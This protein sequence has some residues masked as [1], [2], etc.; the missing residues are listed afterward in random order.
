MTESYQLRRDTCL[1]AIDAALAA[2]VSPLQRRFV[3]QF[4]AKIQTIEMDK[5]VP[6]VAGALALSAFNFAKQRMAGKP[7][8]RVFSPNLATDGWESHRLV[9]ELLNDDMPFLVDSLSAEMVRQGFTVYETLHPIIMV[10]R[11]ESGELLE[12]MPAASRGAAKES[13]IHFELS[14]LPEGVSVEQLEA[15]L[16]SVLE[17]VRISVLDW[18]ALMDKTRAL[19]QSLPHAAKHF[20]QEDILEAQDFLEWMIDRNFVFLGYAAIAYPKKASGTPEVIRDTLLGISRMDEIPTDVKTSSR[21]IDVRKSDRKSVVH[22][23]AL[24]DVVIIKS[25][26]TRGEIIGEHRLYGL[27]TSSVYYQSSESIPFV[28]QKVLHVLS[29]SGFDPVSHD[30]KSLKAILEFLPRDEMFQYT[31]DALLELGLGILALEARPGVRVFTRKDIS[32]RLVNCMVFVPRE[33][34]STELR[35]EICRLLE[36]AYE[37]AL[38]N[39]YTQITDSPL[40]RLHLILRTPQGSEVRPDIATVEAEIAGFTTHWSDKLRVL[41]IARFG[42]TKGERLTRLFGSGFP[43]SYIN[44]FDI[45]SILYDADRMDQALESKSIALELFRNKDEDAHTLHLKIYNPDEEIALSDILPTLEHMGLRAIEEHPFRIAVAGGGRIWIRD[46]R[47][48]HKLESLNLELVKPLFEETLAKV[49]RKELEDDRFNALVLSAQ[50]T[51]R[52]VEILRAYSKY[53][54]QI[55]FTYGPVAIANTLAASAQA[56]RLLV[57]LFE[58]RFDPSFEDRAGATAI[59]NGEMEKAF[60]QATTLAEDRILRA[61]Q[62]LLHA[63]LRTNYYCRTP[64][65]GLKPVLSF[66]FNSKAVPELPLP[67]PH[68]EIF[69]Y[70]ARVEGIHLRG[71]KVA[72]GGL[73]WS[74]RPEDFRTEILGLMKAQMVKNSVI[75]P[76]GSKGGFVVKQP[77]ADPSREAQMKEGIACYTLYL[78]GLLDITD[79]IVEARIVPPPQVVRHDGDDPY[80]V[81]AADKGTATFSDIANS[82]SAAYQ[83]WL[84]DAFASGGSAGYDHKKMA[85]TARGAWVSV[86]RHFREMGVDIAQQDFTAV[87]IGDMSGDVFGNGMLLSK[88]IRLV[89]AFNH[90]H[91][92]IDPSPDAKTSFEERK[93]LFNLPRSGWKDYD[94]K[95]ISKGGGV[96]ERS[97]KRIDLSPEAMRVLGLTEASLTPDALITAILKAPV[98]L[99]WN[100]GIGTYVKS[101]EETHEQVGDR[102]N[103]AVRISGAEVRARVVGEGGN[104]GFTQRGR[105][106]YARAGGRINT[107][108]IDN[109]AGVDCSDH[110]VN[111]KITFASALASGQMKLEERNALLVSMTDEV[112]R[113]VLRDNE[114]QTLAISIAQSQG[115]SLLLV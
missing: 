19:G 7:K 26:N 16:Q 9:V 58:A 78:Q 79:N 31:E 6:E 80:L 43:A 102:T 106:E 92:F 48:I 57:R 8:I 66:K 101:A 114:L 73:R 97:Q 112:A 52:Q 60:A 18:Q 17:H 29:R 61:L 49:W 10:K 69:V 37:G 99:L 81:V 84:G 21:L 76:V 104:L 59:L 107:D 45:S 56:A 39:F 46:V 50:L 14:A 70:A 68:A 94:V 96:Y 13:L 98:D 72:R 22:R 87:G 82:V 83:F 74:D 35:K 41:A 24:M 86:T 85:I 23:A 110:E 36:A 105:I 5:L 42:E 34:F 109:S 54:R 11:D 44:R 25:L 33:Y 63:T 89:A 71:G 77:P 115:A 88:R 95:R 90:M 4:F 3:S 75:V 53:L 103:N 28:R 40:A 93:R 1:K 67:K 15:G 2:D 55:G 30:G 91:I 113:L 65:G 62:E 20:S 100:G 108:A 12:V 38:E 64:Q 111:I 32:G 47:L 27:F 51:W